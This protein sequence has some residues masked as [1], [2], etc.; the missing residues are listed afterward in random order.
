M[1]VKALLPLGMGDEVAGPLMATDADL[2]RPASLL[3][4]G[5]SGNGF[6]F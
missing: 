6:R 3:P 4:V 1:P 5:S 2:F